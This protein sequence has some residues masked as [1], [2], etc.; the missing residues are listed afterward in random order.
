MCSAGEEVKG[1][2]TTLVPNEMYPLLFPIWAVFRQ[3]T[4]LGGPLKPLQYFQTDL[5]VGGGSTLGCQQ[6]HWLDREQGMESSLLHLLE[7]IPPRDA[8]CC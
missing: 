7:G 1:L 4:S 3:C 5:F 6:L 8:W 2:V